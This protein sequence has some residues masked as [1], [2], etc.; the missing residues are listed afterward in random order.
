[1][2][3][4]L[5]ITAFAML[6]C[7]HRTKQRPMVTLASHNRGYKALPQLNDTDT[8]VTEFY[9]TLAAE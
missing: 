4:Q 8:D 6:R 2:D 1:M 5:P 7:A 9:S 3:R